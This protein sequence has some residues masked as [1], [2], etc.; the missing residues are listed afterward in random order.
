[1]RYHKI[2]NRRSIVKWLMPP[3]G[4]L[5]LNFDRVSLSNPGCSGCGFII[6]NNVEDALWIGAIKLQAGTNNDVE[7]WALYKGLMWCNKLGLNNTD[8]E[9]DSKFVVKSIIS[10]N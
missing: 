1:M 6:I 9:G 10:N 7:L 5:K 4:R 8:I 3:A 2:K